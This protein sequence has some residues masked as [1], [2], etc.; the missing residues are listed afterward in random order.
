[1]VAWAGPS[2]PPNRRP[3]DARNALC[4]GPRASPLRHTGRARRNRHPRR[5]VRQPRPTRHGGR[6]SRPTAAR[7]TA[8][9]RPSRN[10]W[11]ARPGAGWSPT[12]WS[13]SARPGS[14]RSSRTLSSS[15]WRRLMGRRR[16]WLHRSEVPLIFLSEGVTRG[17]GIFGRFW[18]R[19]KGD[20]CFYCGPEYH[21]GR[22]HHWPSY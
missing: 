14:R 6:C 19:T 3:R 13:N 17:I 22:N 15:S 11:A 18:V 2:N 1:M 9:I 20:L 5:K 16:D 21:P 8:W 12:W 4:P 10:A 7:A